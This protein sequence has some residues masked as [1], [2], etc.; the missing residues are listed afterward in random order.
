MPRWPAC[1]CQALAACSLRGC[2]CHSLVHAAPPASN[3]RVYV[4][5]IPHHHHDH[6]SIWQASLTVHSQQT[7]QNHAVL[8]T[9]CIRAYLGESGP[10][11]KVNIQS[12]VNSHCNAI[13]DQERL[14]T[15]HSRSPG[16]PHVCTAQQYPTEAPRYLTQAFNFASGPE[17]DGCLKISS[18][19][20]SVHVWCRQVER[21]ARAVV[22]PPQHVAYRSTCTHQT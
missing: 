13:L 17:A 5:V 20:V 19:E 2:W 18:C 8:H 7:S 4:R 3:I 21:C 1:W 14:Y 11:V 9:T 10:Q 16:T 22:N 12:N 15:A 6:V